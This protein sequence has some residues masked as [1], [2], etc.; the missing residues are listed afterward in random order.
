MK[1]LLLVRTRW[2]YY[3][4][5]VVGILVAVGLLVWFITLSIDDKGL[6]FGSLFFWLA[7][8]LFIL[9]PF[10]IISFFSSMKEVQVSDK[11]LIISYVFQK[12]KNEVLFTDVAEM[13][14]SIDGKRK[15][16]RA[17]RNTFTLH[18]SDGRVF[19]FDRAQL[20]KYDQLKEACLKK[21]GRS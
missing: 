12:H 11:G 20:D 21:V 8:V 1:K 13:K 2:Q 3:V 16:S 19:E 6:D 17:R 7:V 4:A 14:S 9:I 18:L 5:N 15:A 10:A